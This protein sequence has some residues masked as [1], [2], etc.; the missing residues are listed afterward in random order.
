MAPPLVTMI[1]PGRDVAA[2]AGDAIA[3]LLA[4]TERRWR[5]ILVDDG[6][7]DAT[8]AVFARAAASDPRFTVLTHETSKGLGAA[9]NAALARVE[10]PFLG[11]LDADDE[12]TPHALERHLGT[13]ESSGSDFVVGAYVRSRLRDGRYV[14]GRVQPWITASTTP[15][16]RGVTLAEHPAASGNI[17]AWSK[18]SRTAFW[19]GRRF[20]EGVAYEDQVLAQ[21]MY[22]QG[23][24]DV[25]GDIVVHWRLRSE[26]T[27]ITQ[28]KGRLPVLRD[29]LAALR[30]GID[31]L[32]AAGASDAV[33]A[34]LNLILAMDVPS[35]EPLAATHPDPAYRE[36]LAAFVAGLEAL[37]EYARVSP[38]PALRDAL[39]W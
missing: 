16:R 10:T 32:R 2:Y 19:A 28:T 12:L 27:S 21:E 33:V 20:P 38:D 15:E 22:V 30:G 14:P 39:A 34:R 9:R 6:S 23:R 36:E 13:L 29:Y 35:L 25:I 26:G 4:Q 18:L 1:V 5:A 8:G 3:S 24:F 11:F 17:V 31:V 37:P 7:T